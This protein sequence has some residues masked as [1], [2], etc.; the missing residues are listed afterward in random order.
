I[1]KFMMDHLYDVV[2]IDEKWFN[3]YK[4]VA[5]Y[6]FAPDEGLPYRSTSNVRYIGKV[7]LLVAIAR[8]QF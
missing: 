7:K 3:M 5:R 1:S 4:G 8:P 2:H 6:C